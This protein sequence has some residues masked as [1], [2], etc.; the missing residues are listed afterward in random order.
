MNSQ[1][2]LSTVSPM[3]A[4]VTHL[5]LYS[6]NTDFFL[7]TVHSPS[8]AA[9]EGTNSMHRAAQGRKP[10]LRRCPHPSEAEPSLLLNIMWHIPPHPSAPNNMPSG[11]WS[12][13]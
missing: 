4:G 5:P 1:N 6:T 8:A 3:H 2:L 9:Q 11:L 13:T 7:N 12:M 10:C